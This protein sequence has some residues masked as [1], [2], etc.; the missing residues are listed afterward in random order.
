[1]AHKKARGERV[2][3]I[4][5]GFRPAA[6]GRGLELV[7]AEQAVIAQARAL[8]AAGLSLRQVCGQLAARG[9]LSRTGRPFAPVQVQ[10]MLAA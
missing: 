8:R 10:R 5:Y 4:P 9:H 3:G 1:L 6:D 2:G 7:P